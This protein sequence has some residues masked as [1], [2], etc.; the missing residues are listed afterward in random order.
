VITKFDPQR[1]TKGT[2]DHTVPQICTKP[3]STIPVPNHTLYSREDPR[4]LITASSAIIIVVHSAEL[5][6]CTNT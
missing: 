5:V 4:P 2:K 6:P 1:C 3:Y